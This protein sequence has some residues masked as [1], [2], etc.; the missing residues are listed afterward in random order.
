MQVRIQSIVVVTLDAHAECLQ[1]LG[2]VS[3]AEYDFGIFFVGFLAGH[4]AR[5]ADAKSRVEALDPL[6][7][8]IPNQGKFSV[9]RSS[10]EMTRLSK[11]TKLYRTRAVPPPSEPGVE[12]SFGKK[13]TGLSSRYVLGLASSSVHLC[14]CVCLNP[15]RQFRSYIPGASLR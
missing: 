6:R 2:L 13:K 9:S 15:K 4:I 3:Q 14:V 11:D 12:L 5:D 1:V 10:G 8:A 7:L